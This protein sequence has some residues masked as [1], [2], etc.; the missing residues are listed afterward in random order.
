MTVEI[1]L[2]FLPFHRIEGKDWPT[3]PGLQIVAPPRRVVRGR[4]ADYLFIYLTLAGNTPFASDEYTKIIAQMTGSFYGTSGSLTA[5]LRSTADIL[6]QNLLNRN[7]STTGQ[8][9]YIV[10]R[11][12]M[13]VPRGGQL[14]VV[15]SGPTHLFCVARNEVLHFHDPDLSGRG[16]GF[17]QTT[18]LYYSQ[19]DLE[20]GDQLVI[21]AQLPDRWDTALLSERGTTSLEALYRKL[22]SISNENINAAIVQVQAGRGVLN[23]LSAKHQA[24]VPE[25][26][27][28]PVPESSIRSEKQPDREELPVLE[29]LISQEH[30]SPMEPDHIISEALT[31][32]PETE[33]F[34]QTSASLQ[35]KPSRFLQLLKGTGLKDRPMVDAQSDQEPDESIG[36]SPQFRELAQSQIFN[37]N[38]TAEIP[39]I[40]RPGSSRKKAVMERILLGLQSMRKFG[41]TFNLGFQNLLKHMLPGSPNDESPLMQGS[42]MAFI[43]ILI[44]LAVVAIAGTV[45]FRYGRSAQFDENY[46]QAINEAVG[47]IGQSDSAIVRRAWESTLYYLDRAESYQVTQESY[48]LRQQAQAALD[49]MDQVIRLDFRPAI[50]GGLAKTIQVGRMVASETD[51]YLLNTP[52]GNV[53]R[54]FLTNQGYQVDSNFVCEPGN[55]A[56]IDENSSLSF[57]V[58]SIIDMVALPRIN[59]FGST[60]MG[61]D[62]TG[63]L[64][65]CNPNLEPKAWKLEEPD[66]RWKNP[67]GFSIA[68]QDYS[69][70]VLDPTGN[71]IWEYGLDEQGRYSSAPELFFSGGFVPQNLDQSID[72]AISHTD[73][74]LLFGDG[75]VTHCTP[76]FVDENGDTVIPI[77]CNDPETMTDTRSG[78]QSGIVLSD[79]NFTEFTFISS[80]DPSLYMLAP[81]SAAIFRFSP[82]PETLF[83]QNQFRATVDQEKTLFTSPITSMAISPN[84]YIFLSSGSQIYFAMDV[85]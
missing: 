51:I 43:A 39:E 79:A 55:Y 21:C 57:D 14:V 13:G 77:R 3:L 74:Y 37:P 16:L 7:L 35:G 15:Q 29:T 81:A 62:S 25:T 56:S 41:R 67:I 60:M 12:I 73:I 84:R 30:G 23:M 83:L 31:S 8:G 82:R 64:I 75:H 45:Y 68:T 24:P 10:G 33:E 38:N 59:D 65:F 58:G 26:Q 5:A 70:Y 46:K 52:Q 42:T 20:P 19:L 49:A 47:A 61:L 85:P 40:K 11:L 17:S 78:H 2:N 4:E 50:I 18:T 1:D 66:I 6:N 27:P 9:H 80:S 72:I 44:P 63:T 54:A 71:A 76:G 53:M 22:Q 32:Q 34:D 48:Q 69:M 28:I 36:V